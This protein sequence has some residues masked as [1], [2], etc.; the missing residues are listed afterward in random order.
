MDY[1]FYGVRRVVHMNLQTHPD[2]FVPSDYGHS[3][4]WMDGDA[5]VVDT[6][7]F[8]AAKWGIGDG[9]DSSEQKHVTERYVLKDEGRIMEVT[10][11]VTDPVYLAEP[12]SRTHTKRLVP[13]YVIT[14]FEACDPEAAR[15]HLE[16]EQQ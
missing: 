9:L 15:M 5:L 1:E 4:G 11:T 8:R 10:Y 7:G 13:G 16:F 3:I 2:D 14:P 6:A 12:F